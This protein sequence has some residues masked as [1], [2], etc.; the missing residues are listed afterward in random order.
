[1]ETRMELC[2]R[3]R[4]GEAD[5]ASV[6]ERSDHDQHDPSNGTGARDRAPMS[7]D[8]IRLT[9]PWVDNPEAHPSRTG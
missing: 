9:Q 7:L 1:M 4:T 5:H 2:R 8:R 6:L 3:N